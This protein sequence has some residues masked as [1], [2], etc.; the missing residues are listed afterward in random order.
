MFELSK[1]NSSVKQIYVHLRIILKAEIKRKIIP[2]NF[3]NYSVDLFS[4]FGGGSFFYFERE[5]AACTVGDN[6]AKID[7]VKMNQ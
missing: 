6:G 1:V 4:L 3:S 2:N 5:A 7:L